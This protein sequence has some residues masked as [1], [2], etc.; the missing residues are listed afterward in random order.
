MS[1]RTKQCGYKVQNRQYHTTVRT[2]CYTIAPI[3][4]IKITVKF[5]PCIGK[6]EE[7][8]SCI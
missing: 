4:Y 2:G 1:L 6:N 5:V 7:F 8:G 3:W